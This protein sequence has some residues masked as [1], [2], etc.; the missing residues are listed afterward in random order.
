MLRIVQRAQIPS[1]LFARCD[2]SLSFSFSLSNLIN[3]FY[4]NNIDNTEPSD[5]RSHIFAPTGA[6]IKGCSD[7]TLPIPNKTTWSRGGCHHPLCLFVGQSQT[8]QL[9]CGQ[10]FGAHTSKVMLVWNPMDLTLFLPEHYLFGKVKPQDSNLAAV[11]LLSVRRQHS[12]VAVSR[13]AP[14]A[15]QCWLMVWADQ[16]AS[17]Q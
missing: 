5:W 15:N 12:A 2:L 13:G 3:G 14:C 11:Q 4:Y 9:A 6:K 8:P 17:A 7:W 1:S 10:L 16:K